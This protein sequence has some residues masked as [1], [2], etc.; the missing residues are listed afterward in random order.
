[1]HNYE[2]NLSNGRPIRGSG[3]T[4]QM[5]PSVAS[6]LPNY[7]SA[8]P[9]WPALGDPAVVILARD[10]S[11]GLYQFRR[12]LIVNLSPAGFGE[13]LGFESHDL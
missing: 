5:M 3:T 9:K 7:A 11:L 13:G 1:M 6:P 12:A 4:S 10:H 2:R 8:T